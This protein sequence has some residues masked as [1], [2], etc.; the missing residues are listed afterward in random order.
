[1]AY[2]LTKNNDG[3]LSLGNLRG[4]LLTLQP[5]VSDYATGGYLVQ[6]I[7]GNPLTA[8]DVGMDKVIFVIPVGGQGG[9]SPVFNPTTSKVQIYEP[10]NSVGPQ[11]EV[12]A[13]TD[14]SAYTFELLAVGL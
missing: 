12:P 4:E 6:G 9:Y 7:G 11:V 14:L 8:G 1:M 5:S 10:S 13:S 2:T 3:D